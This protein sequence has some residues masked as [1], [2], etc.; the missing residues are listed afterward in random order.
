[1]SPGASERRLIFALDVASRTE[2]ETLVAELRPSVGFFKVGLELF[3]SEGPDLVRWLVREGL[4]VFLDLKLYDIPA[5][6]RRS[7]AAASRLGARFITI[8]DA[9]AGA[10]A[11]REGTGDSRLQVLCVTLLTSVDARDLRDSAGPGSA[12]RFRDLDEYVGWR[13]RTAVSNGC[14]G[15]ICSGQ[16]ARR[17]R[18]EL[19][20]DPI[21]VCPGIRL[22]GDR[23]D[24]QK[25]VVTPYRA[26]RDGAD[27]LVV[28]R[29]IRDAADPTAQAR[30]ILS[31]IDRGLRDRE[32]APGP[33]G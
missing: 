17:L 28:G 5:T 7:V 21:L 1:M 4:D 22:G 11:A 26:V 3:V 15:L 27:Y 24:D 13:A 8:H 33:G 19:G 6:M 9:G 25:R 2:A 30:K 23:L 10:A 20:P 12:G 16:N 18:R 29:P 31:E 32:S 14:D